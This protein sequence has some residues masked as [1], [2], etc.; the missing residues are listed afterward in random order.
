MPTQNRQQQQTT[1]RGS[2]DCPRPPAFVEE[3]HA[4][5]RDHEDAFA[6]LRRTLLQLDGSRVFNLL[7]ECRLRH[8]RLIRERALQTLF[9]W[10]DGGPAV[11]DEAASC[12][13]AL[14]PHHL[15]IEEKLDLLKTLRQE[16]VARL[17]RTEIR[18]RVT[19]GRDL[20]DIVAR[21][22]R[23]MRRAEEIPLPQ[24]LLSL[25]SW[26]ADADMAGLN[27]MAAEM[28]HF[29]AVQRLAALMVHL[30]TLSRLRVLAA[31]GLSIHV[32]AQL[33]VPTASI[34]LRFPPHFW[35]ATAGD[36]GQELLLRLQEF[37]LARTQEHSPSD[38]AASVLTVLDE[39]EREKLRLLAAAEGLRAERLLRELQNQTHAARDDIQAAIAVAQRLQTEAWRGAVVSEQTLAVGTTRIEIGSHGLRYWLGDW[40]ARFGLLHRSD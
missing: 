1:R 14:L 18:L 25:Q 10:R 9:H 11:P 4:L 23:L 26:L 16:A 24:R 19:Q 22:V 38:F 36:E 3:I 7:E 12:L 35:R 31:Q 32:Q 13:I 29:L 37:A 15:R 40:G 27:A 34:W 8:G 6:L 20:S 28:E 21:I 39:T 2:W 33:E 17:P 30:G 5:R